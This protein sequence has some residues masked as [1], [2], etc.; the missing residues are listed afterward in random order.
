MPTELRRGPFRGSV[1]VA[2]GLVTPDQLRGASWRRLYRDV[3]A[4]SS[5]RDGP[6]LRVRAAA[7]RLPPGA[8]V[9]GRSAATVWGVDLSDVADPVEI[10][11][12]TRV[13]PQP[14]L[15]V[16]RGTMA[17]DELTTHRGVPVP[18]PKH[19]AWEIARSVPLLDA[20]GWI[21][22]LA[23]AQ[24]LTCADLRAEAARHR[25]APGSRRAA[26]TLALC[27]PRA[28]SPPESCLRTILVGAGL[29]PPIPQFPVVVN[30]ILIA[31]ADLAWP[32]LRL[33]I[34]YDGSWHAHP[35]QLARDRRR[36][37]ALAAA[38]WYVYHVTAADLRD[39]DALVADIRAVL[40]RRTGAGL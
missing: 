31:R 21:D 12:P 4:W 18:T 14:N 25:G 32:D 10:L 13:R 26:T 2:A 29:P 36:L 8:A 1:A 35:D 11:T 37:R 23:R 22:A 19:V 20:V 3:Y 38:G 7:L 24:G 34:E 5:A 39:P 28:E 16:R 33:A 6:A 27:D 40:A 17:D 15:A 9:T 30:G